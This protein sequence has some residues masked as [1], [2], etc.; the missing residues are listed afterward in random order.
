MIILGKILR[1]RS[2]NS[3]LEIGTGVGV[4]T[5]FLSKRI[6]EVKSIDI[7]SNN[8]N[9]AKKHLN[10]NVTLIE[11]DIL[12]LE[13]K[14]NFDLILL[15]D[16]LEHIPKEKHTSVIKKIK[17]IMN[18]ESLLVISIP[19]PYFLEFMSNKGFSL[20]IV[21]EKIFPKDIFK[22]CEINDMIIVSFMM[23]GIDYKNQYVMYQIENRTDE[24]EKLKKSETL[25]ERLMY[26]LYNNQI[27]I[28]I[29]KIIWKFRTN[30]KF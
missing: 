30:G 9:I 5:E 17:R 24:F 19:N 11:G 3:V 4:I 18:P 28:F 6:K 23:F 29:R 27:V 16:V 2:I 7:S 25:K 13:L 1:E 14:G 26:K 8:L 22:L 15:L 12:D 21:D 10:N 20:Q